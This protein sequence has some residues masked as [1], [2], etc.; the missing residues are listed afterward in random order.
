MAISRQKQE[1]YYNEH[2]QSASQYRT[3]NKIWLNLENIST[4]CSSKKLDVCN[5][6][7]TVLESVGSHAYWLDTPPGAH[8]VFH[9][10]LLCPAATDSFPSQQKPD[11]QPPAIQIDDEDE[12]RI[13]QILDEH[14]KHVGCGYRHEY[15]VKWTGYA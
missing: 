1:E 12:Y 7:F 5:A 6:K 13:D 10:V 3:G 8:N 9:V 14:Q 2:R 4:D 11:S 15:R